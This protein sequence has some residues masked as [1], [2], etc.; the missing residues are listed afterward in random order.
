MVRNLHL[1][2]NTYT[3]LCL[4][5]ILFSSYS[6]MK[7]KKILKKM[8][9]VLKRTALAK[10]IGF[11]V[12]LLWFIT[13]I[14]SGYYTQNPLFAWWILFWYPTVWAMVWL[15]GVMDK[16]PL[17]WKMWFWRGVMIGAFMNL[18]LCLLALDNLKEVLTHFDMTFSTTML[19][20]WAMLEWAIIWGIID[21]IVTQKYGEGKKLMK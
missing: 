10:S 3:C 14:I 7:L 20:W 21:W 5:W 17:L 1:Q 15:A 11:L 16:H 9:W 13:F 8:P 18:L 19:I 6:L 12:S 4:T 2:R